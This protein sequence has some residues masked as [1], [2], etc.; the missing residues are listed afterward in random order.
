M[1]IDRDQQLAAVYPHQRGVALLTAVL[2]V[3]IGTLIATN[4][5][6]LSTLDQQRTAAALYNDQGLQYALGAEAWVGDILRQDLEESPDADHLG[7]IWA[8]EISPL[9]IEG[10]FIVGR[11]SDMQG[12]FNINNLVNDEGVEDEV[13][14]AQFE[15]LLALVGLDPGLVGPIVDWLDPDVE[16]RFPTGGEDSAYSRTEPQ[17]IVANGMVTSVTELRAVI[18]FDEEI[19]AA[20]APYVTALPRGTLL[21]VN[22][23]DAVILASLSDEIDLSLAD[24]LLRERG[25]FNFV[26]VESTFQGLVSEDMLP[27]IDGVSD[28]FLLTGQVTIGDATLRI[29]SVMQRHSSGITRTLFRSFGIE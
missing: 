22:T 23:A 25:D 9:P 11:V 8:Q 26:N 7:E 17:Y 27:R 2:V 14:V 16:P 12:L 24:S 1:A 6:W 5:L 13:M 15:R 21:N 28:H 10:G 4:L 29:R 3:A 18:G 19:Y 20:I